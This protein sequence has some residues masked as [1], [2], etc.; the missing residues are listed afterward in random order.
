MCDTAG[1]QGQ[2]LRSIATRIGRNFY[3]ASRGELPITIL[4]REG[5]TQGD[6]LSMVLCGITLVPL[7]EDLRAADPGLISHFYVDDTAFDGL[8]Q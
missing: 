4:S 2:G 6:S 3:S 1:Q 5:V 7:E 8:A